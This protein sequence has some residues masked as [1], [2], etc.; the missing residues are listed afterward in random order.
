[1]DNVSYYNSRIIRRFLTNHV[2]IKIRFLPPYSPEYNPI[3][4]IWKWLKKKNSR[5]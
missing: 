2:L 5:Q 3:E 1:M 4:Q